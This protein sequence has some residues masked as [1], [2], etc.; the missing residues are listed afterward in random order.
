M[1]VEERGKRRRGGRRR[2]RRSA[3]AAAVDGRRRTCASASA[4]PFAS[5]ASFAAVVVL[6][7]LRCFDHV[8]RRRMAGVALSG[9]SCDI[10]YN[11]IVYGVVRRLQPASFA[12][13]Q[14]RSSLSVMLN[15]AQKK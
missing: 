14:P 13:F 7:C 2:R 5:F 10:V 1:P 8:R 11:E 4:F 15:A 3:T 12:S 6:I 9:P